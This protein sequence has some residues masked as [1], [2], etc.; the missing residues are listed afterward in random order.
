MDDF[1]IYFFGQAEKR[2]EI[3]IVAP[4]VTV[5]TIVLL[6]I[7]CYINKKLVSHME[8]DG[9]DLPPRYADLGL[10]AVAMGFTTS[11]PPKY[12]EIVKWSSKPINEIVL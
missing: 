4:I 11:P 5:L 12:D 7:V 9:I 8:N 2:P 1:F 10:P 6:L 3:G